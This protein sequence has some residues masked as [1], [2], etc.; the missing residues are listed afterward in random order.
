MRITCKEAAIGSF[1]SFFKFYQE[2][3]A[4]VLCDDI[5]GWDGEG[6]KVSEGGDICMSITGLHR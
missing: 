6:R 2:V 3:L 4:M 1:K 5:N